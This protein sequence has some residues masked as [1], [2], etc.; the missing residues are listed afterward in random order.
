MTSRLKTPREA[1]GIQKELNK[2]DCRDFSR[3]QFLLQV[4]RQSYFEQATFG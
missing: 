3:K 2:I 1:D 4:R